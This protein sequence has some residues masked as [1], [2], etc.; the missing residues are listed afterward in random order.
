MLKKVIGTLVVVSAFS[1]GLGS[2]ESEASQW[3]YSFI[4]QEQRNN[5]WERIVEWKNERIDVHLK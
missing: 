5:G 4:Y 1:L 2:I 3:N